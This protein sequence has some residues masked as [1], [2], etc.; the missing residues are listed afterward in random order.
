MTGGRI[1][2]SFYPGLGASSIPAWTTGRSVSS[3]RSTSVSSLTVDASGSMTFRTGVGIKTFTVSSEQATRFSRTWSGPGSPANLS[4][5]VSGTADNDLFGADGYFGVAKTAGRIADFVLGGA[6]DNLQLLKAGREGVLQGFKDAEDAWGGDLPDI[7][8]QTI[9]EALK[10]IDE[11]I[12]SLG[13]T[14][15]DTTA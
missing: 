15:I 9:E 2:V 1:M 3:Y 11:K 10:A 7:C 4:A 6:G 12:A 5:P 8:C 14:V 13:E